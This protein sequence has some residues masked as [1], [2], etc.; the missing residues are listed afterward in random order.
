MQSA[1]DPPP[2]PFA[3][4]AKPTLRG[5]NL[6]SPNV[7]SEEFHRTICRVSEVWLIAVSMEDRLHCPPNLRALY[8]LVHSRRFTSR[9]VSKKYRRR[10]K[11]TMPRGITGIAVQGTAATITTTTPIISRNVWNSENT[12]AF[13]SRILLKDKLYWFVRNKPLSLKL[14]EIA[15]N[16][17]P[18][19]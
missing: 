18:S 1:A 17:F 14:V 6:Q 10:K 8:S 13:V 9:D 19:K 11:K 7:N 16:A 12:E 3:L 15:G 5:Q 4:R 2:A